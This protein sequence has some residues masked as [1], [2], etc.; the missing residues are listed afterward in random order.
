MV[1]PESKVEQRRP[2]VDRTLQAV[3][4]D[5]KPVIQ[6]FHR[7]YQRYSG[8]RCRG[9]VHRDLNPHPEFLDRPET[10]AAWPGAEKVIDRVSRQIYRMRLLMGG[11]EISA[12]SYYLADTS[13]PRVLRS[14]YAFRVLRQSHR[15][16]ANGIGTFQVLASVKKRR[17][18]LN[19]KSFVLVREIPSVTEIASRTDH[20]SDIH[21]HTELT[22][23]LSAALGKAVAHL[24]N[25]SF[26]H[27]DLKTRHV[28]LGEDSP[29]EIFFVDLEKCW[30][31]RPFP[32][33]VQDVLCAR[34]LIQLFTSMPDNEFYR[35]RVPHQVLDSYW[36]S[37][38]LD[39][40][41]SERIL[42]YLQ[43]YGPEGRF[44]QGKTLLENVL[45]GFNS[46]NGHP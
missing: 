1:F 5:A 3:E 42:S 38:E 35:T 46:R 6:K 41:R 31:I 36:R 9:W 7:E 18:V 26:V 34:D 12:Y 25:Q 23:D 37:R 39:G 28:L 14:T 27:G 10:V 20:S 8:K 17:V 21:D 22:A 19:R 2:T 32:S 13:F 11:E 43:M 24:H 45:S 30:S 16:L 15:L 40:K 33:L 29:P 4:M 44:R